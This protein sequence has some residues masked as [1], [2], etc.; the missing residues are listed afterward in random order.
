M[1][2]VF[3]V[4]PGVRFGGRSN[5]DGL[6]W[7]VL[8]NEVDRRETVELLARLADTATTLVP[9]PGVHTEL[10]ARIAA[11]LLWLTG[12]DAIEQ[13]AAQARVS[14]MQSFDYNT[15]YLAHPS[16]S[17]FALEQR[18]ARQ[19]LADEGLRLLTRIQRSSNY[20]P[21]PRLEVPESF[22]VA[23]VEA[24]ERFDVT[25]LDR[26]G[27]YTAEDR[28]FDHLEPGVARVAPAAFA[29]LIRRK[30]ATLADR[31][32]ESRH[33][34]GVRVPEH[35]LL[36]RPEEAAIA[37]QL[38]QAKP[39]PPDKEEAFVSLQLLE[40]EVLHLP[41]EEQL[42]AFVDADPALL[43]I[44]LL[45][46]SQPTTTEGVTRFLDRHGIENCRAVQV[47]FSYLSTHSTPV[48][49]EV[50]ERLIPF[51]F[52]DDKENVRT[53]AFIGLSASNPE[54]FGRRLLD[55]GWRVDLSQSVFEQDHGSLAVLRACNDKPLD[56][57]ASIVAPWRLL[58]AARE[59]GSRPGD[60]KLAASMLD[61]A[62]SETGFHLG[63]PGANISVD[64][65]HPRRMLSF[66][67]SAKTD[68]LG[69]EGRADQLREA[70]D[71]DAQW[72]KYEEASKRASAYLVDRAQ[73][74]SQPVRDRCAL[75]R[76]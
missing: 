47:L 51:A 70:L 49:E 1:S 16:R 32:G 68:V 44:A 26:L 69:D 53:L 33:W 67:V 52:G 71:S 34:A 22:R 48:S 55:R 13:R 72:R 36:I 63:D 19:T 7:V 35:L 30:L 73:S 66:S 62:I 46:I 20:L 74:R 18:H 65:T 28:N 45:E 8:L 25:Q 41:A 11:L 12:D 15:D 31:T 60:V 50:F 17:F 57:V 37:R 27:Q 9:E 54:K 2:K 42:D 4:S 64:R 6:R 23:I 43:T 24:A 58:M 14:F 56:G 39:E 61:A 3:C 38:R 75:G 76:R 40:A 59:R 29:A 10:P 5:R 21:D